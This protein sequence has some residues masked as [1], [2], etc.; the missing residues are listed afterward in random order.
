MFYDFFSGCLTSLSIRVAKSVLPVTFSSLRLNLINIL[1]KGAVVIHKT[2][3]V[4]QL[5]H[6][7]Y[8]AN[9]SMFTV[10]SG[11]II[12]FGLVQLEGR[13]RNKWYTLG[14]VKNAM[15]RVP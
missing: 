5:V 13:K 6:N 10:S 7:V 14:Y 2:R 11:D 3:T 15:F 1:K 12:K 4:L 9:I 8:T